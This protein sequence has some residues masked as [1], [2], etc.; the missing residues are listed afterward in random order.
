VIGSPGNALMVDLADQIHEGAMA[1]LRRE[2]TV[3]AVFVLVV[4]V[5]LGGASE[6]TTAGAYIAGA[7]SS[8][9]PD[10]SG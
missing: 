4:A 5:L 7:V 8:A 2:Y 3:L 9:S 10:S 1:F 6:W